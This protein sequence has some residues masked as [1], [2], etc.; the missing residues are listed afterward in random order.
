MHIKY[1]AN[2]YGK[3]QWFSVPYGTR[4]HALWYQA[5]EMYACALVE[6]RK[7]GPDRCL[8]TCSCCIHVRSIRVSRRLIDAVAK[9][10]ANGLLVWGL[11][12]VPILLI[13][14]KRPLKR[15]KGGRKLSAPYLMK[16]FKIFLY[17][18]VSHFF[19]S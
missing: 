8:V 19:F 15:K 10:S 9:I 3:V 1:M 18:R 2:I 11:S 5:K 4:A 6:H 17:E 16:F 7:G 13:S 12:F 14:G